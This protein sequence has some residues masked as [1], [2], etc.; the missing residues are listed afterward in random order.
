MN[1]SSNPSVSVSPTRCK[2]LKSTFSIFT[3]SQTYDSIPYCKTTQKA[4]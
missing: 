1:S 3:P 4:S 2:F